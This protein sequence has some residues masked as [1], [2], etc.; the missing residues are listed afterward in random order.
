MNRNEFTLILKACG[1]I[2]KR[3][4]ITS[5]IFDENEERYLINTN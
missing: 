3:D 5:C 4:N 2:I 1:K